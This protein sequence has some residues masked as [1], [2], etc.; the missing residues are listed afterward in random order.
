MRFLPLVLSLLVMGGAAPSSIAQDDLIEPGEQ[1]LLV[2]DSSG[3]M[4]GQIDGIA[5]YEIARDVIAELLST[6]DG[7]NALGLMAYGHRRE[8]DCTDIEML[9]PIASGTLDAV[10]DGINAVRPLGKTPITASLR[11][12]AAVISASERPGTVILLTDG[13]ETCH[14]DPCAAAA[15]LAASGINLRAHVVGFDLGEEDVSS[16][17][18]IADETGGLFITADTAGALGEAMGTV[19]QS[20]V[21]NRNVTLRAV[22]GDGALLSDNVSWNVYDTQTDDRVWIGIAAEA[23]IALVPGSYRVAGQRGDTGIT[24]MFEVIDTEPLQVDVVFATG[25]L[26]FSSQLA[27]GL[28]AFEQRL[29][30]SFSTPDG[31][32]VAREAG[33]A[34]SITLPAGTYAGE[35]SAED[36]EVSFV[37]V[38]EVGEHSAQVIDLN[39]GLI[40]VSGLGPTGAATARHVSWTVFSA[41]VDGARSVAREVRRDTAF[42]LS[43]GTYRLVGSYQGEEQEIDIELDAGAEVSHQFTFAAP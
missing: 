9:A 26:D 42:L 23:D 38:F 43:A 39:A 13:L 32:S 37:A 40:S 14:A 19:M 30:W 18:C 20:A 6:W 29:S 24:H 25:T 22:D 1:V 10:N 12:A 11:Q 21:A 33:D 31:R 34:V 17:R 27:T 8:G 36:L 28:P 5:K 16:L 4:W 7:E 41:G 15:E 2:L 3:S 35:V